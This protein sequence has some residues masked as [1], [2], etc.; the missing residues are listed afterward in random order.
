MEISKLFAKSFGFSLL[1]HVAIIAFA[2]FM[3]GVMSIIGVEFIGYSAM[4]IW[5]QVVIWIITLLNFA[6]LFLFGY[7]RKLLDNQFLNYLPLFCVTA[8][9]LL[10]AY[11][12][13]YL[14]VFT[15]LPFL[16]LTPLI[17]KMF[18]LQENTMVAILTCLPS[19]VICIGMLYQSKKRDT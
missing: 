13:P 6:L 9:F 11:N 17:D 14:G 16:V 19:I 18:I 1:G 3:L 7:M 10:I 12:L 5:H 2:Y 15:S 8:L 4:P